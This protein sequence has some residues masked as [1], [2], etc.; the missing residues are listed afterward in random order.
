MT[1]PPRSVSVHVDLLLFMTSTCHRLGPI[2]R[3][4]SSFSTLSSC[5]PCS[6]RCWWGPYHPPHR[7]LVLTTSSTTF[8]PRFLSQWHHM[9]CI[10]YYSS[11]DMYPTFTPFE[12]NLTPFELRF[13]PV[14]LPPGAARPGAGPVAGLQLRP[15]RWLVRRVSKGGG[16]W[17]RVLAARLVRL[18]RE[19]VL[20]RY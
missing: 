12:P 1:P 9:T 18:L 3:R 8:K 6:R 20:V 2:L 4:C 14:T 16:R 7:V 19:V 15:G 10:N 11:P 5:A 13:H 17:S